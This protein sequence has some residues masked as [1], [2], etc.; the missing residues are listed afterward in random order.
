MDPPR[1]SD[2]SRWSTGASQRR[3]APSPVRQTQ[4]AFRPDELVP[5]LR[6]L[7]A[8]FE[9]PSWFQGKSVVVTGPSRTTD[10]AFGT[11]SIVSAQRVRRE[12]G[13]GGCCSRRGKGG[14]VVGSSRAR[15]GEDHY[16][17]AQSVDSRGSWL[18][19]SSRAVLS[20]DA[21]VSIVGSWTGAGPGSGAAL[22]RVL[23]ADGSIWRT[24]GRSSSGELPAPSSIV[25]LLKSRR[26][27][28]WLGFPRDEV[29]ARCGAPEVLAQVLAR[30]RGARER[31][32]EALMRWFHPDDA[33]ARGD[34]G[35][36]KLRRLPNSDVEADGHQPGRL[37]L[38]ALWV[39]LSSSA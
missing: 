25:R 36:K 14:Q 30:G 8:Q 1:L 2:R 10:F 17:A 4:G 29:V 33:I 20:L 31:L 26:L 12:F 19:G 7:A 27:A 24:D 6:A 34:G 37:W 3:R 21:A 18:V 28:P 23:P 5:S 38:A 9:G 35:V 22:E 15:R 16:T 13:S 11:L 32:D 39:R